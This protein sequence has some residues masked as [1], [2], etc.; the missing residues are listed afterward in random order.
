MSIMEAI[1][2]LLELIAPKQSTSVWEH[3]LHFPIDPQVTTTSKMESILPLSKVVVRSIQE[4]PSPILRSQ[5]LSLVTNDYKKR[6][7]LN[8]IPGLTQWEIDMARKHARMFGPGT[9][10]QA[11][12]TPRESMS[13][14]KA[15]HFIIF[16]MQPHYMLVI[17]N[18]FILMYVSRCAY[19]LDIILI[20]IDNSF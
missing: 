5:I 16:M 2:A 12:P 4:A 9:L 6:E 13:M 8:A 10:P 18:T 3:I 1:R 20:Y 7:L 11:D 19:Y 15:E 17:Y 14:E